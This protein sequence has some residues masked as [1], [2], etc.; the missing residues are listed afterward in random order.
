MKSASFSPDHGSYAVEST[1]KQNSVANRQ[2]T[3]IN[4][5]PRLETLVNAPTP[6]LL[7]PLLIWLGQTDDMLPSP[8]TGTTTFGS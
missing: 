7:R 2:R 3:N 4:S 8:R 1:K 5:T 6:K